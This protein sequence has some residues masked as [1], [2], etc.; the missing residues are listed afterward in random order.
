M[1]VRSCGAKSGVR[2]R[3]VS[4]PGLRRRRGGRKKGSLALRDF[5]I[6]LKQG[7]GLINMPMRRCLSESP[8]KEDTKAQPLPQPAVKIADDYPLKVTFGCFS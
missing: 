6:V 2:K 5:S 8:V 3:S 7:E 1:T 4:V